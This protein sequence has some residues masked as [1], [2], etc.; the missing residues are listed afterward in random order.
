MHRHEYCLILGLACVSPLVA[1]QAPTPTYQIH[2]DVIRGRVTTD[3]GVVLAGADVAITM[4]PDRLSQFAKTDAAGRYEIA[5]DKGTGDYLVHIASIGRQAFRKRIT[6]VGSDS[7][8]TVDATLKAVV[9]QLAP[10]QVSAQRTK[11][12]RDQGNLRGQSLGAA[13]Q[14]PNGVTGNVPIDQV[15]NLDAIAASLPGVT[16]LP[17]GGVSVL[18]L[19][20]GQNTTTLNGLVFSGGGL[21]R[22][23][24]TVTRVSLS[25][26]DPARGGFSGAQ[27][28]VAL[29]PGNITTFRRGFFTLD[30]PQLQAAVA[31]ARRS[32][33]TYTSFD[34]NLGTEG[35]TNL[36]RWMFNTGAEY[37]RQFTDATSLLD[38]DVDVLQHSGVARDS[39]AHLL[40]ALQSLGVPATVR[41]VPSSRVTD[42]VAF[43]GRL[44][45]PLFDYNTFTPQNTTWG[46]TGFANFSRRGAQSLT[47]TATPA[48]GGESR[49]ISAG[50]QWVYS[51]YFGKLK[52]QLTDLRT[53]V[54][55]SRSE[56]SPYLD[57]PDGRVLLTSAFSNGTGG[58]ASLAFAG[59]SQFNATTQTVTW[60]TTNETQF[61]WRGRASH[62]GKV[63][64]ESR[65]DAFSQDPAANRLGA[66]SFN[67]L[68]DLEANR[69]A[70]FTRTLT[71]PRRSGGEWS[72]VLATSD[73]WIVTPKFSLLYGARLEG[74]KF[75]DP[76]DFN[77][78]IESLFG[79]RTDHAP[80]TVH[81]S[82]RVGFNWLWSST[83]RPAASSM[84][85]NQLGQFYSLP[86]GIVRGGF[87]EFR[88]F[89]DAPLLADASVS[90]GLPT[91]VRRIT[92]VGPAV[93]IPNWRAYAADEG[94]I[95]TDCIG[96]STAPGFADAAPAV[97]LFD[98]NYQPARAWRGNLAWGSFAKNVSYTIDAVY[99]LNVNQPSTMDL[100]FSGTPKFVIASDGN[101][102]VFVP[103]SSIVASTGAIAA[104]GARRES[105]FGPV[106]SRMSD[107]RGWTRQLTVRARPG[108]VGN[109]SGGWQFDGTYTFAQSRSQ[110]R[111]FDG[112]G[113]GDPTSITWA[114]GD[115]TPTHE[116]VLQAGKQTR[117]V[118]VTLSGKVS[119]GLPYTPVVGSDVN[120]DGFAN[121]RAFVFAN[122]SSA[123]PATLTALDKLIASTSGNARDCLT[124]QR[125]KVAGRNSCQGPWYST[126]NMALT[127]GFRLQQMLHITRRLNTTLFLTNPLGGLDQLL[128]GNDLHGWGTPAFPDRVLYY[129]RGFDSTAKRYRY[130]VNPRFGD[131][132]PTATTFRVPFRATL[133][134]RVDLSRDG[135][136]QQLNRILNPGR[137]G[138]GG[139]KLESAAI[140][141]R[142][143]GN[144]PDW[145][146]E[147]LQFTDSLL[148]TR[149]QVD[150]IRAAKADYSGRILA[151]WSAWSNELARTPDR[152]DVSDLVKRQAKVIQ[153]AWDM[154]RFESQTTLPKILTPI[155]LKLLPGWTGTLY[156]SDKPIL[157]RFFS[158]ATC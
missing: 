145:Y 66:F 115:Y 141:K 43:L 17:G 5:F 71:T 133:D 44:D 15:G 52:D 85:F 103:T 116:F 108:Q 73:Q 104:G 121:D 155:Q 93:P 142:Y 2:H 27:T 100:N 150:A 59:N 138:N 51:A 1:Q 16:A 139:A 74:N 94:S 48:H 158:S 61:Y 68:S 45:R 57:L 60:E 114:R 63:F 77:P 46:L 157:S 72:G 97:V 87:G 36:D 3:S 28:Q 50:G 96:G 88:Q 153:D 76:P 58:V 10:V 42:Y 65:F 107:L 40:S 30:A 21:P 13:E 11:P 78:Q 105:A 24:N 136:S 112:A 110:A 99:S 64:A 113:F 131:T 122:G 89:L 109:F 106:I 14:S 26:Y 67:S 82:P 86:R 49:Q 18:G 29:A 98:R 130:E 101:R 137:H 12:A 120:G 6:R 7:V 41:G 134:F 22:A 146:S 80:N 111:G 56:N 47:S 69:P 4:A 34:L 135:E 91:G 118:N 20:P 75:T 25:T 129:V 33:L 124:R 55:V 132:R 53:G 90:T 102:P 151:H 147:L 35:A 9:Q 84:T 92:C 37:K 148:L 156:R 128:H 127:P 125:G 39:V 144:L 81:V 31:V 152:Y 123:D 62:R 54:S 119:S 79:A 8:F 38:A 83:A 126:L 70:S 23:A 154:A 149:D 117:A 95:P 19:P 140:I 32:G 143:C